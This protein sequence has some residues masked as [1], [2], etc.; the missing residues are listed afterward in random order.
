M[1]TNLIQI[2]VGEFEFG[3]GSHKLYMDLVE[4]LMRKKFS[5]ITLIRAEEGIGEKNDIRRLNLESV[6]FNN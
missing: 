6:P 1:P 2:V 5:G 4:S 3:K